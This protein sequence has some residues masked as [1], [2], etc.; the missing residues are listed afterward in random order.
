MNKRMGI[1]ISVWL[2]AIVVNVSG[3]V[4]SPG[5]NSSSKQSSKV[6]IAVVDVSKFDDPMYGIK[7]FFDLNQ[8]LMG[9]F[10]VARRDLSQKASKYNALLDR[11]KLCRGECSDLIEQVRTLE[12]EIKASA[13]TQKQLFDKRKA[14]VFDQAYKKVKVA[15]N[16]FIKENGYA[17]IVES[18]VLKSGYFN[19]PGF[20]D[21]TM[22]FIRFF[23]EKFAR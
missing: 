20:I 6:N 17:A 13:D 8:Q 4:V 7:S 23:N 11:I 22:E 3:Q 12:C 2:L 19:S 9:E 10:E 18:S 21:V 16:E 5:L 1:F 15:A 14:V